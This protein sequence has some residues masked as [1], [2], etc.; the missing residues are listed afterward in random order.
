MRAPD[1]DAAT[2]S[3]DDAL[4]RAQADGDPRAELTARLDLASRAIAEG[5]SRDAIAQFR[6]LAAFYR[7]GGDI[8]SAAAADLEVARL[9]VSLGRFDDA[10]AALAPSEGHEHE[11]PRLAQ[12]TGIRVAAFERTGDTPGARTALAAVNR[13]VARGDWEKFLASDA[14]RLG[15]AYGWPTPDARTIALILAA[16]WIG[17]GA[18]VAFLVRRSGK[19]TRG[20]SAAA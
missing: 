3:T 8:A 10:F 16:E 17:V 4:V 20:V 18:L 1:R 14:Q 2:G 11:S 19:R 5:R 7:R 12:R 9:L 6:A 15:V 13:N